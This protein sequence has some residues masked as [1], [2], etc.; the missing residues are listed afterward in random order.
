MFPYT[1]NA[2][3][4][5]A[6]RAQLDAQ[7]GMLSTLS[8]RSCDFLARVSELNMQL[9]RQTTE[10]MFEAGRQMAACNDPLQFSSVALHGWQPMSEHLRS[11]GQNLVNVLTDAQNGL[12]QLMAQAPGSVFGAPQKANGGA[13]RR[14]S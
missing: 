7:V 4:N 12:G 3:A 8:Q 13:T 10:D 6:L 11:Y 1:D 9:A 2:S 14:T 5:P